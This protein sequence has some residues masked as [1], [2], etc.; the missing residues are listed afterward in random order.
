LTFQAATASFEKIGE[1]TEIALRVLTEKVGLPSSLGLPRRVHGDNEMH[2]AKY[3]NSEYTKIAT[4][5]FTS[6]RKRMATLCS[7]SDGDCILFVKGAPENVLDLCSSV[8]SNQSGKIESMTEKLREGLTSQVQGYAGDALRVLALAMKPMRPYTQTCSDEDEKDLVFLG[9][10]GMIDPPRPEV[11][12]ALQTCKDAGIRVIMVTGDN[13]Q[14]AE[15]IASQIGL[16]DQVDPLTGKI[17]T[18]SFKGKSFTGVE[19]D[20]MSEQQREDA[21]RNM[22]VF[23]RVEPA[24]K[25]KLVEILKR[26][27]NIVAMTGDGVNDAPALKCADIGIAMGSGTAVAKGAADMVLADDNFSTIVEAVAEGRA[28]YNNTKQFIRYMVSSNI[29][30]VVCIFVAAALGFP[31]T[32]VPVQL[33]W[34]NLVTDGL[35]ATA[36]GFNRADGDI[37]RQRPRSPREQI[38]DRWLLIRYLII[39]TY[40]GLA[41]VGAF[42]WWFL[43]YE[44]GPKMPW[45]ELTMASQCIGD[46]CDIFNDRRPSTMA[47]STLVLV[48]MFNALNS[49]SENKSLLTH[50]PTT[51]L[52]VVVSVIISMWLHYIIMYVPSFAKTFTIAALNYEEWRAVFLFSFPVIIIDEFLKFVTRS[53]RVS[54]NKFLKRANRGGDVLPRTR[55]NANLVPVASKYAKI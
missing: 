29:G 39:G 10:V 13:Q 50:P 52:F 1:A 23:S 26:Q 55:S 44:K 53:H 17:A 35:P 24:Q 20:L 48:E 51:N 43:S 37:M 40:V 41:T 12:Y 28:I 22:C 9:I 32:L 8:M 18:G 36:L 31:E 14:T 6:E 45:A 30:E 33:L 11:K 4:A 54:I 16:N 42:G 3:W 49:L 2:C 21:A 38:V 15:A 47:M 34:V 7:R 27:D 46:A 19:F 25:S 5:E